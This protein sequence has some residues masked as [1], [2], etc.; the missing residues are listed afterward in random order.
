MMNASD[1]IS[2]NLKMD[3]CSFQLWMAMITHFLI[4]DC[5]QTS[6]SISCDFSLFSLLNF[7]WTSYSNR[8][9]SY[10]SKSNENN[11]IFMW[12]KI[13][14]F[15]ESR[16]YVPIHSCR[17]QFFIARGSFMKQY[18]TDEIWCDCCQL[19]TIDICHNLC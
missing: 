14:L 11:R 3:R 2:I 19:H 4:I 18:S 7:P 13:V 5:L 16:F 17:C 1:K 15:V 12:S 10:L 8:L 6:G 9:K